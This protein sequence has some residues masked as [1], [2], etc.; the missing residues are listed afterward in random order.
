[1]VLLHV[2]VHRQFASFFDAYRNVVVDYLH[3]G[4]ETAL[5]LS[6]QVMQDWGGGGSLD[7]LCA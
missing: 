1:M 7:A 6:S 3:F 2:I 5:L 4:V